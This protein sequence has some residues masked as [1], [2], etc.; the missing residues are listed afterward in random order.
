MCL[1]DLAD[2]HSAWHTKRV[3]NNFN[4]CPVSQ[5]RHVFF[6]DNLGDH[7]FVSM[8]ASHLV[9]NAQLALARNVNLNLFDNSRIDVIAA[10]NAVE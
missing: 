10:F 4:R 8:A 3:E 6:R 2:V 9:S 7:A 1:Q 5:E